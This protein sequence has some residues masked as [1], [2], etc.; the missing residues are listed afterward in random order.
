[1]QG[2]V[3]NLQVFEWVFFCDKD[4]HP[5]QLMVKSGQRVKKKKKKKREEER[6]NTVQYKKLPTQG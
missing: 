3:A 4:V 5:L 2:R 6:V 1:M